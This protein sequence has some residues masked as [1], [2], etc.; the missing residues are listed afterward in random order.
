VRNRTQ[1]PTI[2]NIVAPPKLSVRD[3]KFDTEPG[4]VQ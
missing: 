3:I 1:L 2:V 4:T